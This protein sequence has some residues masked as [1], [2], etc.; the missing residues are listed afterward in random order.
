MD[1]SDAVVSK[2]L[3]VTFRMNYQKILETTKFERLYKAAKSIGT[4]ETFIKEDIV[5]FLYIPTIISIM[6]S[7]FKP[8]FG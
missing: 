8:L 6:F 3:L 1:I 7:F 5:S 4:T 2:Y